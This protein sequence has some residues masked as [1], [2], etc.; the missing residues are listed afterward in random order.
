MHRH[1]QNVERP[2]KT[3]DSHITRSLNKDN[4]L[5]FFF[6]RIGVKFKLWAVE[7]DRLQIL[8][9]F[10]QATEWRRRERLFATAALPCP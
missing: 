8:G 3:K 1:L 10:L 4:A 6:I 5:L 9:F 2:Y 7:F